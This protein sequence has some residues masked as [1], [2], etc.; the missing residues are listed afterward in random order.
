L[1]QFKTPETSPRPLNHR[2]RFQPF[3]QIVAT[4]QVG[5]NREDTSS[6][7]RFA[8]SPALKSALY[9]L[10][11]ELDRSQTHI[12]VRR[13]DSAPKSLMDKRPGRSAMRDRQAI[14]DLLPDKGL[15]WPSRLRASKPRMALVWHWIKVP[16]TIGFPFVPNVICERKGPP[17]PRFVTRSSNYTRIGLC[18][19][20]SARRLRDYVTHQG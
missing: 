7:A 12:D 18:K 10:L 14:A 1:K 13:R 16:S 8:L 15:F 2:D 17:R 5:N 4:A 9:H 20:S 19:A 11:Y 6:V 3:L